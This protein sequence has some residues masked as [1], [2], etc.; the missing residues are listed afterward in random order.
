MALPDGS[1][2]I[3][4]LPFRYGITLGIGLSSDY[5]FNTE[6]QRAT[7]SSTFSQADVITGMSL[8][9]FGGKWS[10]VIPPSTYTYSYRARSILPG[11]QPSSWIGPVSARPSRISANMPM[12]LA[13]GGQGVGASLFMQNSS[14]TVKVGSAQVSGSVTKILRTPA[15]GFVPVSNTATWL[16]GSG[17]VA[18]GATGLSIVYAPLPLPPGVTV[19]SFRARLNRRTNGSSATVVLR[20]GGE[21]QTAITTLS[22]T[23]AG[24]TTFTTYASSALNLLVSATEGFTMQALLTGSSAANLA[25]VAWTELTYRMPDYRRSI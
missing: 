10:D 5:S 21:I 9:A 2:E 20:R 8:A 19:V 15:H 4:D 6:I 25:R 24:S 1:R 17:F 22:A 18:N 12:P 23:N 3:G 16:F 13:L 11:W 7:T 14:H